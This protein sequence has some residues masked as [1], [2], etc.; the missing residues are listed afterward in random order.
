MIKIA[1]V[2]PTVVVVTD[3]LVIII[4]TLIDRKYIIISTRK[5]NIDYRNIRMRNKQKQKKPIKASSITIQKD[6][7]IIALR[8]SSSNILLNTR[9][10]VIKIQK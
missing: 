4:E 5:K 10:E 7:L 6:I 3:R 2:H 8:N 9:K 1:A